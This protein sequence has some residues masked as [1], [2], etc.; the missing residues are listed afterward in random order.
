MRNIGI[1]GG[2]SMGLLYTARFAEEADVTLYVRR[3]T[4]MEELRKNGLI[5]DKHVFL[6]Q[7]FLSSSLEHIREQDLILIA[8]KSYELEYLVSMFNQIPS[9]IPLL[10]IQNGL[11]HLSLLEKLAAKHIWLATT[12]YGAMRLNDFTVE[13]KGAGKTV[14]GVVKGEITSAQLNFLQQLPDFSFQLSTNIEKALYEKLLINVAVNPLTA[15]LGVANG[16]ILQNEHWHNALI[17]II[18]EANQVLHVEEA[19]SKVESVLKA[20]SENI[21]SMAMDIEMGRQT[22]IDSIVL[23]VIERLE[24]RNQSA[25]ELRLLYNIIKGK[26]QQ[27]V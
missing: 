2:G 19:V 23:P 10:F 8:V 12:T 27:N 14:F 6:V 17:Q 26:E 4:Q 13:Q 15:A 5:N 25:P 7:T 24:A 1:I 21:S 18:H 9:D 20:T 3:R 16:Q 11:S 22:E